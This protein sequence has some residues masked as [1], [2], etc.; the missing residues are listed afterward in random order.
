MACQLFD[1]KPWQNQCWIIVK[2]TLRKKNGEISINKSKVSLKEMYLKNIT[3]EM[4]AIFFRPQ[5]VVQAA[6]MKTSSF[7]TK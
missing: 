5:Y 3:C 7:D 2:W 6:K 4:A 1:T